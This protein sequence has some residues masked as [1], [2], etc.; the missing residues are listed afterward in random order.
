MTM[1]S[2]DNQRPRVLLVDDDLCLHVLIQDYLADEGFEVICASTGAEGRELAGKC[3]PSVIIQDLLLPDASGMDMLA[4]YSA[5][6]P[7]VPVLML[8]AEDRP[9]IIAEC[10]EL[11][12]SQCLSK[13]ADPSGLV[14]AVRA[15][16][17]SSRKRSAAL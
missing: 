8:T 10:R 15:A 1:A 14:A 6:C 16:A 4:L 11:G 5:E 17:F 3:C 7:D 9:E 13:V 2:S 12:A